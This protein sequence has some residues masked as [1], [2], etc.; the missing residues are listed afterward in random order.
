MK[1]LE[2]LNA[3]TVFTKLAD[4]EMSYGLA[5]KICKILK[6]FE[7]EIQ[8]FEKEKAKIFEKYPS[9]NNAVSPEVYEEMNTLLATIIELENIPKIKESELE[10]L[11]VTPKDLIFIDSM[12]D[13]NN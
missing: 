13:E 12:I 6:T 8:A 3:N 7:D 5:R 4:K 10:L 2:I 1:L 9:E 11:A